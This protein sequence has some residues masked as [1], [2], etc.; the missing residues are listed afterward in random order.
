MNSK[1][2]VNYSSDEFN[3]L[4]QFQ[5]EEITNNFKEAILYKMKEKKLHIDEVSEKVG[6]SSRKLS[7]LLY[8]DTVSYETHEELHSKG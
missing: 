7:A 4:S 1:D 3:N 5:Q 2:L 6:Y 8:S